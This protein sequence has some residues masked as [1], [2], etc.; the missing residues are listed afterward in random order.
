MVIPLTD[1]KF[2]YSG[3]ASKNNAQGDQGGVISSVQILDQ[4][5][6]TTPFALGTIFKDINRTQRL[7]GLR[8]YAAVYLKNTHAT[9]T[10]TE[11]K[12]FKTAKTPAADQILLWYSGNLPNVQE[13]FIQGSE[14]VI[15]DA[16][17]G[18]LSSWTH[19][20]NIS[21]VVG[22]VVDSEDSSVFNKVIAKF[23]VYLQRDGNPT[24]NLTGRLYKTQDKSVIATAT[25]TVNVATIPS[26]ARTLFT[27]T[28]ASPTHKMQIG[29]VWGVH[30]DN[31][32][33]TDF[34]RVFR[35]DG[36]VENFEHQV[37][38]DGTHWQNRNNR[39][40]SGR[41]LTGAQ[42]GDEIEPTGSTGLWEN[43]LSLDDAIDLPDLDPGE[44][45]GLWLNLDAPANTGPFEA[46]S[47][48]LGVV[49]DSPD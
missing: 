11:I 31:G 2:F 40:L 23:E 13:Q 6:T 16:D 45:V 20:G 4:E 32:D 14:S 35:S 21:Q 44:W 39:D 17:L 3:G 48:E 9:Q 29:D 38:L 37:E 46:N 5:L 18:A 19:L 1:M 24:G 22:E 25:E 42:S 34:V 43:P 47:F 28:F 8:K 15:Y 36:N 49:Y 33:D 10:A 12:V 7:N 27:F 26:N 30:F 41:V